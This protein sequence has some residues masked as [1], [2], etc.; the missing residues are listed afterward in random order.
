[1]ALGKILDVAG[2]L[3]REYVQAQLAS[4]RQKA[5]LLAE[6][7]RRAKHEEKLIRTEIARLQWQHREVLHGYMDEAER[8][9][10]WLDEVDEAA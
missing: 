9:A 2:L 10:A 5:D 7:A 6:T 1:M 8:A 3:E 4:M